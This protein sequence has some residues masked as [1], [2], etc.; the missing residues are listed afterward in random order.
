MKTIEMLWKQFIFLR[1]KK[2]DWK[3]FLQ[4]KR[5]TTNKGEKKKNTVE[6]L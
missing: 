6:T 5:E 4:K 2:N 1:I 3:I